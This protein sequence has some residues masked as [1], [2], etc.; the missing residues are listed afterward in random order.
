MKLIAACFKDLP[1]LPEGDTYIVPQ[2]VAVRGGGGGGT[3]GPPCSH[4][5]PFWFA[6]VL[7]KS[8]AEIQVIILEAILAIVTNLLDE[9]PT[10]C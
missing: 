3:M 7:C 9:S 5:Q 6:M 8:N 10:Y 1:A 2:E 4:P